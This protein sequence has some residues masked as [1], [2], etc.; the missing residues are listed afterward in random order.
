MR[1]ALVGAMAVL[2]LLPLNAGAA[3]TLNAYAPPSV[4]G[5]WTE[6]PGHIGSVGY[7]LS[8]MVVGNATAVVAQVEF[9]GDNGE[10]VTKGFS[11]FSSFKTG[12]FVGAP[13]VR[14]TGTPLG[15][16]V[17]LRVQP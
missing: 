17:K 10:L 16:A 3:T 12:P 8:Y 9:V 13:L 15:Y 1:K 6:L 2:F 7:A 14:F 11:G 4:W 5:E